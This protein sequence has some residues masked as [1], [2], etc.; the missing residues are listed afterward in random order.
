MQGIG[1]FIHGLDFKVVCQY[2]FF[3]LSENSG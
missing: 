1:I 3:K 2:Q